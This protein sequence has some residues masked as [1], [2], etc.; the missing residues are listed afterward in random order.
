MAYQ[1]KKLSFLRKWKEITTQNY[2]QWVGRD[3]REKKHKISDSKATS[4]DLP[5]Q[6]FKRWHS[7]RV[8]SPLT[9]FL[10]P[11]SRARA[12]GRFPLREPSFR[13]F[14]EVRFGP[15]PVQM[16][17]FL[18][19]ALIPLVV[20]FFL[21]AISSLLTLS[22]HFIPCSCFFYHFLPF[23]SVPRFSYSAKRFPT[24]LWSLYGFP[25]QAPYFFFSGIISTHIPVL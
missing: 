20:F 13:H 1:I 24:T 21:V 17:D 15:R 8:V 12:R 14:D 7:E 10:S 16:P 3:S 11:P 5:G 19:P 2:R 9:S 22:L 25:S 23:P 18:S 4:P 6:F